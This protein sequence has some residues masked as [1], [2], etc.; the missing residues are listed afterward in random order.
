MK[1]STHDK[2]I[3]SPKGPTSFVNI[4][5]KSPNPINEMNPAGIQKNNN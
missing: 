4:D 3:P 5:A 2:H 1:I